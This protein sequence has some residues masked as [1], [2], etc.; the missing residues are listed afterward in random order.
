MGCR[1]IYS[2]GRAAARGIC[3]LERMGFANV[4]EFA[5][6]PNFIFREMAMNRLQSVTT[7]ACLAAMISAV[8]VA[9]EENSAT[10]D[11]RNVQASAQVKFARWTRKTEEHVLLV[12][13]DRSFVA[14][15]RKGPV[16]DATSTTVTEM[17][18]RMPPRPPD[19]ATPGTDPEAG[20]RPSYFVGRTIA[21]LRGLDPV[22]CGR[23]LT[24]IDG[25]RIGSNQPQPP[26][27]GPVQ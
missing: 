26:R 1:G 25:R 6:W 9:A 16:S 19:P 21:N 24:L 27:P 12:S 10:Q 18:D 17:P 4:A 14:P 23:T 11:L 5:D 7:T 22:F 13:L 2:R 3:L 15:S 8:A 20:G